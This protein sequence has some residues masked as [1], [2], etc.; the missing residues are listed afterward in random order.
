[1]GVEAKDKLFPFQPQA[2]ISEMHLWGLSESVLVWASVTH[3]SRQQTHLSFPVS[4][5]HASLLLSEI[6]F[7]PKIPTLKPL[8]QSLL[9]VGVGGEG[10][11]VRCTTTP[12]KCKGDCSDGVTGQPCVQFCH[13]GRREQV[14][15]S[16]L[17]R[18]VNGNIW[19]VLHP[20]R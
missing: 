1:M 8:S 5:S 15:A 20:K 18:K 7:P 14:L 12:N 13:Y 3:S 16:S 10:T 6:I 4:F 19:Q 9:C 17:S 2:D 11:K